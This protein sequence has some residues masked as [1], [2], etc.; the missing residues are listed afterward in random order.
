MERREFQVIRC[1]RVE[2]RYTILKG[3]A[4]SLHF[5]G[6]FSR[7]KY[8]RKDEETGEKKGFFKKSKKKKTKN[9]NARIIPENKI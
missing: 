1:W 9:K 2:R 7:E 4:F 8:K 6:S 5:P 3:S